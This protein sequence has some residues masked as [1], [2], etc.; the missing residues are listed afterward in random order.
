VIHIVRG[1]G[2]AVT[3]V[4]SVVTVMLSFIVMMTIF[5]IVAVAIFSVVTVMLSFIITLAILSIVTVA[6]FS[7]ITVA[8]LGEGA[9]GEVAGGCF[10]TGSLEGGSLSWM[11]V[12]SQD[13]AYIVSIVMYNPAIPSGRCRQRRPAIQSWLPRAATCGSSGMG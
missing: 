5:S 13:G 1:C 4:L 12:C 8:I 9:T 7:V 11:S 2:R 3:A 6:I 10:V